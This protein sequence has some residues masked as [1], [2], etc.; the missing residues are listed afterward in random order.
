MSLLPPARRSG[1]LH[2]GGDAASTLA[3][4]TLPPQAAVAVPVAHDDD[5]V[6]EVGEA[7]DPW[8]AV[9]RPRHPVGR[10]VLAVPDLAERG[11]ASDAGPVA[12]L[13]RSYRRAFRC[14]ANF[15]VFRHHVFHAASQSYMSDPFERSWSLTWPN[16]SPGSG[17]PPASANFRRSSVKAKSSGSVQARS[18]RRFPRTPFDTTTGFSRSFWEG[19]GQG[20]AGEQR[21]ALSSSR[22]TC[23]LL[24]ATSR[25][26]CA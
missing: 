4:R 20:R 15:T 10:R 11:P 9:A 23:P 7:R 14:A 19:A 16:S 21:D 26:M 3:L 13:L 17:T 25:V 1:A 5:A 2:R 18:A 24:L 8:T 6:L 22:V 12:M